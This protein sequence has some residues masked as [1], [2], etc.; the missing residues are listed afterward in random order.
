MKLAKALKQKNVLV[1]EIVELQ[2]KF[3]IYNSF[4]EG[5]DI[6]YPSDK[7]LETL[8]AKQAEL[9]DLKMKIFKANM[10]IQDKIFKIAECKTIITTLR[11][12]SSKSGQWKNGY[13]SEA[14]FDKYVA[15]LDLLTIDKLIKNNED[16][17]DALQEEIDA[18][19][20]NTEI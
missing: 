7:S 16:V 13:G 5:T 19:N 9:V 20:H 11:S 4:I 18:Y 8:V 14:T 10:P 3:K 2:N 1:K 12:T 15:T 6:P 17:I